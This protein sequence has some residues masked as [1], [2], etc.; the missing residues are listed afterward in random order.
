MAFTPFN[1]VF[2]LHLEPIY[3]WQTEEV[4]DAAAAEDA[5]IVPLPASDLQ[6]ADCPPQSP[7]N[8][9]LPPSK[10]LVLKGYEWRPAADCITYPRPTWEGCFG[11]HCDD[12][13]ESSGNA[14]AERRRQEELARDRKAVAARP[15]ATT[16]SDQP[17]SPGVT[18]DSEP[19]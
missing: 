15:A 14:D 6:D 4:K 2:S 18:G 19:S 16:P 17:A 9:P 11:G 8:D 5:T 12:M 3:E 10:R 7:P 1:F 13:L